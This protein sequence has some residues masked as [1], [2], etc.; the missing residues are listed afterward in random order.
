MPPVPGTGCGREVPATSGL[1]TGFRRSETGAWHLWSRRAP[2]RLDPAAGVRELVEADGA[3]V[4]EAPHVREGHVER[5]AGRLRPGRVPADHD[6]V[7][8]QA[9]HLVRVRPE[10]L[11]PLVVDRVEHRLPHRLEAVVDAAVRQ[12]LGLVPDD[13]VGHHREGGVEIVAVEGLVR[14]PDL[15]CA[16][17][18]VAAA[19]TS[20][21]CVAASDTSHT[22][23]TTPSPS[24][25]N[26]N[27]RARWPYSP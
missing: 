21:G 25:R 15:V 10:V 8:A 14:A 12:P 26:V 20:S 17:H 5:A 6:D 3:A 18:D 24:R 19:S 23:C 7:V 13:V 4:A 11:P 1:W 22:C 2:E 9:D 27:R 16:A